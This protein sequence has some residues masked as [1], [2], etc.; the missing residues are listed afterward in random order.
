MA[1]ARLDIPS[2]MLYGGSIPPGRFQ[3]HD[4]TI[5]DV[6]EAVGAH[7]RRHDDAT[8]SSTSW[9]PSPARRRRLRRPVHRQHDGD[10]LR[11]DG[12]LARSGPSMVPAQDATKAQAAYERRRARHGRAASAACARATSSPATSLENAI[13]AITASGGSTNGVLHLL[14]VAHEMGVELDIDDF[15]RISE[16]TPLLC[17]LKPGRPLQRRRPVPTP[18]ACRRARQAPAR[19]RVLH[20][21]APTVTGTHGRRARRRGRRDRRARSSSG[22]STS[23]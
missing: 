13:A 6:F 4:V 5:M 19:A 20:R 23:R 22:R 11:G 21:D 7:R 14:A 18:A 1:L 8:R 2:V 16:R 10:G 15:D 12:H 9:S 17:D 3:G